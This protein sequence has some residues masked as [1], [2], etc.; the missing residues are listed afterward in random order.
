MATNYSDWDANDW[1]RVIEAE[2]RRIQA[3]IEKAAGG[4]SGSSSDGS[5]GG[6][7]TVITETVTE[8]V[9][10]KPNYLP[11]L[12]LAWVV[13]RNRPYMGQAQRT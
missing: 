3:L 13:W 12:L 11:W 10:A 2:T 8:T 5:T 9:P 4:G 7:T 1:A 6:G